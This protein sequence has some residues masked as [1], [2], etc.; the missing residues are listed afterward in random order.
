MIDTSTDK[1]MSVSTGGDAGP[2]IMA[3]V[4][5]LEKVR[6]LLDENT[7][8][9]WVDEIAISLNGK[10][11]VTVINLGRGVDA[12]VVQAFLDNAR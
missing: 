7:I 8:P 3:P 4:S 11:E 10:P 12:V 6:L 9:Y 2:Y 5:Q 1:P